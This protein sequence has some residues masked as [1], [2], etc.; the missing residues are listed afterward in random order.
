[1]KKTKT[2]SDQL[3]AA[4]TASGLT[5]YALGKL[6]ATAPQVVDRFMA[7]GDKRRDLRGQTID[8]L[9]EALNLELTTRKP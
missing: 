8:K 6:S 5:H 9:C 2:I 7:K 3:R 4:I 1:M